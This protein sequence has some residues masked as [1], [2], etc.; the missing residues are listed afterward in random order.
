MNSE[1]H[2]PLA[3]TY[4]KSVK[5]QIFV[6]VIEI[7]NSNNSISN[8]NDISHGINHS[9]R[10]DYCCRCMFG[11]C[12]EAFAAVLGKL[13]GHS[14]QGRKVRRTTK[15]SALRLGAVM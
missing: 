15:G 5:V 1:S 11:C 7:S 8:K 3:C 2:M 10:Y 13:K 6:A 12:Y 14:F 4:T 9:I